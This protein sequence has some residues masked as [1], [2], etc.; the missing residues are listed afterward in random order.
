MLRTVREDDLQM[1]F[2]HQCDPVAVELAAFAPRDRDAFDTHWAKILSNTGSWVRTVEIGGAVAGYICA[3]QQGGRWE[4][5]YWIGRDHWGQ[6][7]GAKAVAEFLTLFTTRP[8]FATVAAHNRPSLR[9]LEKAGFRFAGRR[10]EEDGIVEI[11]MKLE[12]DT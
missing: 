6:G 9:I 8:V 1:F 3:F 11:I 10:R 12:A 7:I 5:A 2:E 4:I